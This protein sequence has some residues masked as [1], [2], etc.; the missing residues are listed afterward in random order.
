MPHGPLSF[1]SRESTPQDIMRLTPFANRTPCYLFCCVSRSTVKHI[2]NKM[3]LKRISVITSQAVNCARAFLGVRMCWVVFL[4]TRDGGE[5][6]TQ[7]MRLKGVSP[8]QVREHSHILF[9]ITVFRI[10][11]AYVALEYIMRVHGEICIKRYYFQWHFDGNEFF[12]GLM[13]LLLLC[14]PDKDGTLMKIQPHLQLGIRRQKTTQHHRFGMAGMSSKEYI[15]S[16]VLLARKRIGSGAFEKG[17]KRAT[18]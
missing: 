17:C 5:W 10:W 16:H 4:I 15:W 2:N 18:V 12:S 8:A 7:T 6:K 11:I 1:T 13:D 9:P 14:G 3:P